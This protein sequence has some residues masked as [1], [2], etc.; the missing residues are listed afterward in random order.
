MISVKN[1]D[2][3]FNKG[4]SNQIHVIDNTSLNLP[5]TGFVSFLG[6][7]GS[8]KTTLFNVIGGLDKQ[9][10]GSIIYD[11]IV[12]DEY[13]MCKI[14][15]YRA[16]NIGYIFQNYNL[17]LDETVYENL[18]IA[19]D[20][21]G[22]TDEQE[23]KKRIEYALKAV[24]L[25]KYRK[26]L[27][28]SLSGGEQQRVSIARALIKKSRMILADEPT[29]NLDSANTLAVMNI[30]K[31]ISKQTLVLL[32]THDN[33]LA[34]YYSDQII[35][36][37]DGKVEKITGIST[38]VQLNSKDDNVIY[39]KDSKNK[40]MSFDNV[41]IDLYYTKDDDLNFTIVEKNG[42]FYLKSNKKIKL[43]EETNV[44]LV[45]DHYR[46]E[47]KKEEFVYD[48]S[49]Y[50]DE[51]HKKDFNRVLKALKKSIKVFF[52]AHNK[53]KFFHIAFFLVGIIFAI[54]N[55]SY[56]AYN[57]VDIS[58]VTDDLDSY[59]ISELYEYD[60][61]KTID[62]LKEA[63]EEGLLKEVA[64]DDAYYFSVDYVKNTLE[65][66]NLVL[67]ANFYPLSFLEG[68]DVLCGRMPKTSDECII[69]KKMAD[70][71]IQEL[72]LDVN[73]DEL[74][75]SISCYRYKIVGIS[76]KESSQVYTISDM[77]AIYDYKIYSPMNINYNRYAYFEY[78]KD[79]YEIVAG[80]D[81]EDDS[82][83]QY[84]IP[85]KS[86]C[87]SDE[88][89]QIL[90]SAEKLKLENGEEFVA[91]GVFVSNSEDL[92]NVVILSKLILSEYELFLQNISVNDYIVMEGKDI[93]NEDEIIVSVYDA[94]NVGDIINGYRVVG[95]YSIKNHKDEHLFYQNIA[96]CNERAIEKI[97]ISKMIEQLHSFSYM[98]FLVKDV[99]KAKEFFAEKDM[100]L[101]LTHDED[102]K[103]LLESAAA[104]RTVL[105]IVIGLLMVTT[106]IYIYFTMRSKM[107]N[108]IYSI[109]VYR[110]LGGSRMKIIGKY[111]MESFVITTFT[112]LLGYVLFNVIYGY[113]S[114]MISVMGGDA[115]RITIYPSTYFFVLI[116]Y[117][118][119]IG[120]GIMPVA[121]LM[122]KTP[123][124]IVSKY[125]I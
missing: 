124:E 26:K 17:L 2:K 20:I 82:Q 98:Q 18:R 109:G 81:I 40:K 15:K 12:F 58:A 22:V 32:V 39:L 21:I 76:S 5:N 97:S 14:D 47:V 63:H 45:D 66:S 103:E 51:M 116:M 57:T 72:N 106:V 67:Y 6:A 43:L 79:K 123:A 119:N 27:A 9:D 114:E 78:E 44:K 125:D 118:L 61:S 8:G 121:V 54:L 1:L 37:K 11:D 31:E 122:C 84:L 52:M 90:N 107:I 102:L 74:L 86:G 16:K 55:V 83:N 10:S 46:A 104:D 62:T 110:E 30:L 50:K 36:I 19:L 23:V 95:K 85:A 48:T 13:D 75:S 53:T 7:S 92:E 73:Y 56:V 99:E 3:F 49:W 93:V 70:K 80:K 34:E 108:D 120:F 111:A 25:Y 94:H 60:F 112:T 68:Y 28:S 115:Q 89:Q 29:G 96:I 101:V 88:Y 71:I 69:G 41:N 65:N 100:N 117:I 59:T 42:T 33:N 38:D 35:Y 24:K 4:K 91:T 105:L 87:T 113:I 77:L 64:I